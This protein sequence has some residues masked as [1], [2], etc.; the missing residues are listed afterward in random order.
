MPRVGLVV[1]RHNHT[2]VERNKLKRRLREMIR[3]ARADATPGG[4]TV[5]V[6][7]PRAYNT[8]LEAL[9]R[10]FSA[11]WRRAARSEEQE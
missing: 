10:E 4:D 3:L 11:L 6:A 2:A 1:P 8:S 7:G 9:K 5:I